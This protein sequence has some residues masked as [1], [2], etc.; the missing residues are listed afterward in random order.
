MMSVAGRVSYHHAA[1]LGRRTQKKVSMKA[2]HTS[3]TPA[4]TRQAIAIAAVR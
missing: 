4:G 1:G 2:N 3:A